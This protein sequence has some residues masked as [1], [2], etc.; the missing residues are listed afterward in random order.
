ME[1]PKL[2][3]VFL[4]FFLPSIASYRMAVQGLPYLE[5]LRDVL[6]SLNRR[7]KDGRTPQPWDP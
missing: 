4:Y 7:K 2:V 3:C 5:E 6:M 1:S